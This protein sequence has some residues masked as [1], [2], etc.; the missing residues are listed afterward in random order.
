MLLVEHDL[1][2]HLLAD[3][4]DVQLLETNDLVLLVHVRH[5][6]RMLLCVV[7][8]ELDCLFFLS[9]IDDVRKYLLLLELLHTCFRALLRSEVRASNNLIMAELVVDV[10]QFNNQNL[11]LLLV[12]WA[13]EAHLLRLELSQRQFFKIIEFRFDGLVDFLFDIKNNIKLAGARLECLVVA[14]TEDQA[15]WVDVEEAVQVFEFDLIHRH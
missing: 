1:E 6:N 3:Q 10:F 4:V 12:E 8:L 14:G 2:K 7:A 11:C 13:A 5:D 15:F 9:G